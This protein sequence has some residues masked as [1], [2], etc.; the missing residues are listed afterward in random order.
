MPVATSADA[1]AVTDLEPR[2][3]TRAV[4]RVLVLLVAVGV[5]IRVVRLLV[6][7]PVWGDEAMLAMNFVARDYAA[8]T[9]HLDYGQ[10][11]PVLFL[12]TGRFAVLALGT[13]ELAVRFFPFLAAVGGLLLF[14]D[15]ARRTVPPT[16]AALAV[17]ILA[18]SVWPVSMAATVKPYSGDLF[19]SALLLALAARWHRRPERP[20]S[21]AGLVVAVPFALAGSYPGVFVAGAVSVYLLPVAWRARLSAKCLFVAYNVA[22]LGTFA[23]TYLLIGQSQIDPAAGKTGDYMRWYWRDGF[24]PESVSRIPTWLFLAHT[25]RM[26]AYPIG[27]TN[28]ASVGTTLLCLLGVWWCWRNGSRPLLALCLVPFALNLMAAVLGKYPYAGCCRL[29][30]HLAPAICLLAGVGWAAVMEW[31]S[32]A[33]ANRLVLVWW[34]AGALIALGVGGLI[35]KCLTPDRD[36]V[37]R[38]SG[39]LYRELKTELRPG[40]RIAVAADPL[41]DITTRWYLE[42]F[43]DRVVWLKP[44][45]PVPDAERVWLVT[46]HYNTA[47]RAAHQRLVRSQTGWRPGET[48]W[49]A[50]R[51]GNAWEGRAVWWH[52]GV[53]CLMRPN[54]TRTP[55]KLNAMP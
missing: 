33:R 48:T 24:P 12:W 16:A 52:A 19:W 22:M 4:R 15:F 17:G 40:D 20:W 49:Y 45:Q 9:R 3:Y 51:P 18:V 42:R 44:G 1:A 38:F 7:T 2:A 43:G 8:L 36:P 14:W 30:Q 53:T 6:P 50:V 46:T 27:D 28:A 41:I 54:N 23:A 11:A 47:D 26:F 29:S 31:W 55:P 34:A 25:G 32:P 10:V 13:S 21:L 35:Y 37:S 39:N 5:V